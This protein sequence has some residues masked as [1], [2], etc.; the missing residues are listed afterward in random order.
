MLQ[1]CLFQDST[2]SE[3]SFVIAVKCGHMFLHHPRTEQLP[4]NYPWSTVN[5]EQSFNG[6]KPAFHHFEQDGKGLDFPTPKATFEDVPLRPPPSL[7]TSS[8]T[9]FFKK[10]SHALGCGML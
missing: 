9:L 1:T 8:I 2:C 5:L 3:R 7:L 10:T 6:R 4:G